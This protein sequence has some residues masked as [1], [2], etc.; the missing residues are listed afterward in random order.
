MTEDKMESALVSGELWHRF[1]DTLK[2]AGDQVLREEAPADPATRAEGFR[3]LSRLLRIGLEMHLE[4]ADP[5]FPGFIKPSH[6]TAK[7]GADN[8]DNLYLYARL[9]GAASYRIRGRRNSV[10]YLSLR[11]QKG[12]YESDG[13]MTETGFID[14]GD[15]VLDAEGNFEIVVSAQ[16]RPGNWLPMEADTNALVVRQTFHDRSREVGAELS[17][18]RIGADGSAPASEPAQLG[19]GL[20]RAADFVEGTAR[21]FADWAQSYLPHPNRLQP[22][23]QALC[24]SVGGDP[25]IFYYHSYWSLADDEALLIELD[26]IPDC[27]TWNLQVNNYWLESLDYRYHRI[28]INKHNARYRDDGGVALVLSHRDPG[29]TNWL[30][31]AGHRDG[32]LCFRWVGAAEQVHP[33]TRVVKLD[34]LSADVA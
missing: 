10:H 19:T 29:L 33:T 7:I 28:C 34:Q 6:E 16:P 27:E 25:N 1:C 12:G 23:D 21:L 14:A 22:A 20:L 17:I 24:Q 15:L 5:D 30:E 8:P 18:E 32:T 31:T 4:F 9:N 26:R 13:K 3:Y 2:R 11:T